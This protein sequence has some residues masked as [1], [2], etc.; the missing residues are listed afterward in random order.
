LPPPI[1]NLHTIWVDMIAWD[2]L[3]VGYSKNF[4]CCRI[5]RIDP[6]SLVETRHAYFNDSFLPLRAF[7]P[8]PDLFP[9]SLLPTFSSSLVIPFDDDENLIPVH[10]VPHSPLPTEDTFFL[11]AMDDSSSAGD[12]TSE[13]SLSLGL[14][15]SRPTQHLVLQVGPHPCDHQQH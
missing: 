13:S 11:D 7:H 9:H 4:S 8:S 6:L 14:P 12:N 5:V 2:G 10:M 15:P 1:Y 3:L